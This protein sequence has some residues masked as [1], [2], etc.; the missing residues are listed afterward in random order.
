MRGHPGG[1]GPG[2][3]SE[4]KDSQAR[5]VLSCLDSA[6]YGRREGHMRA[7]PRRREFIAGLGGVAVAWPL[8]ASAQRPAIPFIGYLSPGAPSAEFRRHLKEAGLRRGP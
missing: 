6:P 3:G 2:Q 4:G 5:A 7:L 8:Y 1:P